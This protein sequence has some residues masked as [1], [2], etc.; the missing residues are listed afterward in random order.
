[1]GSTLA[2]STTA[3]PSIVP[4]TIHR[5]AAA[6]GAATTPAQPIAPM[7]PPAAPAIPADPP[8]AAVNETPVTAAT[9]PVTPVSV[10][11]VPPSTLV[12]ARPAAVIEMADKLRAIVLASAS[13]FPDT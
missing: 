4:T 11:R 9:E 5:T 12:N 13:V 7:A 3:N 8:N 10:A 6:T 1:M 2:A